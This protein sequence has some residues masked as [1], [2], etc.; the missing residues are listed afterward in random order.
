MQYGRLLKFHR[1]FNTQKVQ[2][3]FSHFKSSLHSH[4]HI[5][6][7]NVPAATQSYA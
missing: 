7:P 5:I 1:R 2:A 4:Q 3:A 6:S